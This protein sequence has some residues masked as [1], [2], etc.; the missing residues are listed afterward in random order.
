MLIVVKLLN[1]NKCEIE[2]DED[3]TVQQVKMKVEEKEGFPSVMMR[4]IFRGKLLNDPS[5]LK[6]LGV[7]EGMTLHSTTVMISG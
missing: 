6:E 1:G 3:T 4:L 7:K 2:V 5:K